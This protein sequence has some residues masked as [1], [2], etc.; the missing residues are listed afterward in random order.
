M[1]KLIFQF[2]AFAIAIKMYQNSNVERLAWFM[3]GLLF[4]PDHFMLFPV[5]IS[6]R[7]FVFALFVIFILKNYNILYNKVLLFPFKLSFGGVLL[8]FLIISALDVRINQN[9]VKIVQW[10]GGYFFD[11]YLV[12]F[13]CYSIIRTFADVVRLYKIILLYFGFISIYGI[14]NIVTKDNFYITMFSSIYGVRDFGQVYMSGID[15]R[16]R[17]S[18]ITWHPIYYGFVLSM[19]ILMSIFLFV[20]VKIRSKIVFFWILLLIIVNMAFV[21]SRT[22]LF[23]LIGGLSIFVLLGMDIQ[24]KV[25]FLFL[26]IVLFGVILASVPKFSEFISES[27]NT[28]SSQGSKLQGS[29]VQMRNMQ[30]E[31]ALLVFNKSPITGNGINYITENLGFTTEIEDRKSDSGFAGFESYLYKMLI[32][33]GV[34]GIVSQSILIISII[35]YLISHIYSK[36]RIR[37]QFAILNLGMLSCFLLFIFGTGDLGT[38]KIF[39]SILGVNLKGLENLKYKH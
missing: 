6:S 38:F 17:I 1:E 23:S 19:A 30:L 32:E 33:Q 12:L 15:G 10:G 25:R 22:P 39:F 27:L 4:I 35:I 26:G 5:S 16:F 36:N 13:L 8:S 14:Y 20:I 28:F 3:F 34:I 9:V 37:K 21:N 29:S 24:R 7:F 11:N 18:S 2:I 31:S